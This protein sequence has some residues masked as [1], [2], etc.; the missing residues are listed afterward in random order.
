MSIRQRGWKTSLLQCFDVYTFELGYIGNGVQVFWHFSIALDSIVSIVHQQ[1]SSGQYTSI[2]LAE[3]YFTQVLSM[4]L[5]VTSP[6]IVVQ[7]CYY[8]QEVNIG[9][10]LNTCR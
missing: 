8:S 3:V 10:R 4:Q 5:P 9:G 7:I 6:I 1:I 2:F